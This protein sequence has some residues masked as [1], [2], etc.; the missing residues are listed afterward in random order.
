M[1]R[2]KRETH[3]S[4]PAGWLLG[5]ALAGSQFVGCK[6]MA[7]H[8]NPVLQPPP[9]RVTLDDTEVEQR[10]AAAE[11]ETGASEILQTAAGDQVGTTNI[12]DARIVA[13]VNGA[14]I[15]AADV[16]DRF[17]EQLLAV[18]KQVAEGKLTEAQY[19]ALREDIVRTHLRRH[20]ERVLLV[21]RMRSKLKPEQQ[22]Q[23][24]AHID[25]LFEGRIEELKHQLKVSTR[26]EL[27]LE[28]NK[29]GTSLDVVKAD[30]ANERMAMEFLFSSIERPDPPTRPQIVAYYQEHRE[31]YKIPARVKWREVKVTVSRKL[32]KSQAEAKIEQARE[33]LV[34]GKP[35]AAVVAE[36][37]DGPTA[38]DGGAWDWTNSGS[39]ADRELE[40]MLFKLPVNELSAVYAGRGAYHVVQVLERQPAGYT[41]FEEVQ[42][43]IE[44]K[45][46]EAALQGLPQQFLEQLYREA[47]IETD[48]ELPNPPKS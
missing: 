3:P 35:F 14:P 8:D 7:K 6:S 10:I 25:K 21:E 30:Y 20:I 5:L 4:K 18:E 15:F 27:E 2:R 13:R 43:A 26:T 31:D 44:K 17:R 11:G 37:S 42:K 36:Y 38:R 46:E 12:D 29:R 41:P 45:L 16:L 34:S 1:R 22:K 39:L 48:Y 9:R 24:E 19:K 47:I 40:A 32:T 23:V 33:A 28:L